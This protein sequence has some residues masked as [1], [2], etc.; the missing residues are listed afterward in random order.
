MIV[1]LD[2]SKAAQLIDAFR[3][4]VQAVD[5]VHAARRHWP[6]WMMVSGGWSLP[7]RS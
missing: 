1:M 2:T 5:R 6:A 4:L 3:Y 7:R